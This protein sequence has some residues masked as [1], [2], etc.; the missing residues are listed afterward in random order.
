MVLNVKLCNVSDF[1]VAVA[2]SV[3]I[4]MQYLAMD[5]HYECVI[6]G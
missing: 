5:L 2:L 6:D 1:F 4:E 3:G